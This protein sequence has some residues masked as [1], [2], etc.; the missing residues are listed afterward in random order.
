M[1]VVTVIAADPLSDDATAAAWL[2]QASVTT[3]FTA[4]FERLVTAYRV[5]AADPLLADVDLAR[6]A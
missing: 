1:T 3:E 6:S 2:R 4:V 5:A